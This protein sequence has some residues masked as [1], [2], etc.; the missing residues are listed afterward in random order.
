LGGEPVAWEGDE[1]ASFCNG[2]T[3][4]TGANGAIYTDDLK[5]INRNLTVC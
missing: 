5:G 2:S 3:G 1:I 4:E